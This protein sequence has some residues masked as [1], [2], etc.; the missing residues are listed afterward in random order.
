MVHLSSMLIAFRYLD[1]PDE[2]RAFLIY[3]FPPAVSESE[4]DVRTLHA[5]I[6]ASNGNVPSPKPSLNERFGIAYILVNTLLSIHASNWLHK[7]IWSRSIAIFTPT[8]HSTQRSLVPYLAG[9]ESARTTTS[10]SLLVETIDPEQLLYRHPERYPDPQGKA[11]NAFSAEHDLYALGV[12][13][14]EIGLWRTLSSISQFA[15][16]IASSRRSGKLPPGERIKRD[17]V[18]RAE[19]GSLAREMGVEYAKAVA[20]CL[21]SSFIMQDIDLKED[22]W[23]D[24]GLQ[25]GFREQVVEVIHG[26]VKP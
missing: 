24:K 17:L 3:Q 25:R 11:R 12:V 22:G 18:S 19:D 15:K 23:T 26:G 20:R 1:E 21:K 9:W 8:Q 6:N 2:N 10:A 13:L 7:N 5:L 14:L 4:Q 16:G